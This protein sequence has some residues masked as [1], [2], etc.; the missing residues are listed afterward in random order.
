MRIKFLLFIIKAHQ[1]SMLKDLLI[2]L[3]FITIFIAFDKISKKKE[4]KEFT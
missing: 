4:K 3:S 2:R 1:H